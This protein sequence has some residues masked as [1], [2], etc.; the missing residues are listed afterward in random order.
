MRIFRNEYKDIFVRITSLIV[1]NCVY[2]DQNLFVMCFVFCV[3][4]TEF[5]LRK[6]KLIGSFW[7][8]KRAWLWEDGW[9]WHL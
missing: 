4:V 1:L 3:L 6:K 2:G 7:K 9:I 5:R 8:L